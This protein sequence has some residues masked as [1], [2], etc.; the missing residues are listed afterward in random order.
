ML[1]HT[2]MMT[3][4]KRI[5]IL[6]ERVTVNELKS[7]GVRRKC[8]NVYDRSFVACKT[9]DKSICTFFLFQKCVKREIKTNKI[10]S[11]ECD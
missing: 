2:T 7:S 3:A 8:Q 5:K 4:R 6:T 1:W 10:G 11:T 9:S